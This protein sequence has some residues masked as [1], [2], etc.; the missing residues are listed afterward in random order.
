MSGQHGAGDRSGEGRGIS[1]PVTVRVTNPHGVRRVSAYLEQNGARYPLF[2]QTPATRRLFWRKHE[3]PRGITFE[4]GKNKAPNL[5]EGKARLVVEAVSNDLRGSTTAAVDVDV[6]L[7]AAARDPGRRAALYQ[8][9][10]HGTGDVHRQRLLERSR[11]EG[12]AST[13]SAAFR[14]RAS[15][16]EQRFSMFAAAPRAS[17]ASAPPRPPRRVPTS[18]SCSPTTCR[19]TSCGTCRTCQQLQ[20]AGLTFTR[21]VV[22]DSLCCPSRS[23]DLHRPLPARHRRLHQQRQRTAASGLPR[24]GPGAAH[25]RDGAPAAGLPHGDDGQVPQ[26]LPRPGPGTCR[27]AGRR[28]TCAGNG[29]A[30]FNYNLNENGAR[31][32]TT[33][34]RRRTT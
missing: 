13:P 18:C 6:V 2:E 17:G 33:A 3:P 9:G 26:R 23:L 5:K 24:P 21:Y 1:T 16:P 32:S 10:R 12:R 8:P 15:G 29:Y 19:G 30:E 7:S 27:P 34:P 31:S 20:S 11:R 22:T 4:A 25:L 28:G 14:C